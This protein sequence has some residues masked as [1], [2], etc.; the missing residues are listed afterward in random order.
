MSTLK[1]ALPKMV[2]KY[3]LNLICSAFMRNI[4]DLLPINVIQISYK[5]D[6]YIIWNTVY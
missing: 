4:V 3:R 1:I 6:L 5:V 2:T